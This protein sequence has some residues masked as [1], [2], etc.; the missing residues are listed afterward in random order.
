MSHVPGHNVDKSGNVSSW[1]PR[2]WGYGSPIP[3]VT[4]TKDNPFGANASQQQRTNY[5]LTG[6][7]SNSGAPMQ[8][9]Q[10]NSGFDM[11]SLIA[12]LSSNRSGSGSGGN[13]GATQLGYAELA[14]KKAKDEKDRQ[15]ALDA[16]GYDRAKDARIL[17]GMQNYYNTGEY[18]TGF[19]N[20]LEMIKTQGQVSEDGITDAYGRA[21]TNIGKGYDV[22][23]GLGTTGFNALNQYLAQN[24]NNPYAGMQASVGSAPDALSNYLSAYGVSDQP[25]QGQIQADQ[26]QAQQGAGNYQNLIDLLGA[27]AQQGAASRGAESQMAQLLFNTGLG[28]ERAGYT[29]QAENAQAQALAALQQQMFQS[30]F[31]VEG[32]RN[33]LAN[34][35]VQTILNAG[36]GNNDDDDDDDEEEE[37]TKQ[38]VLNPNLTPQVLAQLAARRRAEF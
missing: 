15:D 26:L 22:A 1:N 17:G 31:G 34:Q 4:P 35:L 7:V 14:Y 18:G 19:D 2:G 5:D 20:L 27:N 11:A 16:L 33:S 23:S 10:N 8:T 12:A 38:P 30:R 36:G 13:T 32:D 25:V 21:T 28:Q 6:N 37:D 3:G 29:S 9:S 24:Q